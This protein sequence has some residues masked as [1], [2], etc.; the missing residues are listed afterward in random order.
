MPNPDPSDQVLEPLAPAGIGAIPTLNFACSRALIRSQGPS[1]DMYALPARNW[2]A[3]D[4]EELALGICAA[5]FSLL[6]RSAYHCA[7]ACHSGL[8]TS[9]FPS[10]LRADFPDEL[11]TQGSNAPMSLCAQKPYF[12]GLVSALASFRNS[13]VVQ[14]IAGSLSP[15][16]LKA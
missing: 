5:T 1:S 15:A 12:G 2:L 13:S 11:S 10:A 4:D 3:A 7:L 8:S 6:T 9:S 14:P 16:A